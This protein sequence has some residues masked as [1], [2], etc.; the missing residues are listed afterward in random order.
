MYGK[1]DHF[2]CHL[3]SNLYSLPM[4]FIVN[5]HE[6]SAFGSFSYLVH[7]FYHWRPFIRINTHYVP[8]QIDRVC[9]TECGHTSFSIVCHTFH[10]CFYEIP[11][12]KHRKWLK[13]DVRN[14]ISI[15]VVENQQNIHYL[16]LMCRNRILMLRLV[17]L[18]SQYFEMF[19]IITMSEKFLLLRYP[20]K[21]GM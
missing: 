12:F 15:K 14:T 5:L 4:C 19:E 7:I 2:N 9:W 16:L 6:F 18:F 10:L 8:Q 1:S 21:S 17:S 20:H 3:I 11:A 13:I